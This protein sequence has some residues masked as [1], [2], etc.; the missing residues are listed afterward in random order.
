VIASQLVNSAS[1]R[2]AVIVGLHHNETSTEVDHDD[3]VDGP[4]AASVCQDEAVE[5]II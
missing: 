4:R 3:E 1:P 2:R 5:F